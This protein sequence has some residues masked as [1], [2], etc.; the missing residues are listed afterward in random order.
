M[1]CRAG[2]PDAELTAID[3]AAEGQRVSALR[4][5]FGDS[6]W[7]RPS[8]ELRQQGGLPNGESPGGWNVAPL[9]AGPV[10]Q[11]GHARPELLAIHKL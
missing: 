1:G 11:R 9:L 2:L 7:C 5:R 6:A 4:E 3:A 10:S 8:G